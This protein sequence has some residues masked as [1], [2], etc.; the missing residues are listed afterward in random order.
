MFTFFS[1]AVNHIK[2]LYYSFIENFYMFL[3]RFGINITPTHY[4]MADRRNYQEW[5]ANNSDDILKVLGCSELPV[6]LDINRNNKYNTESSLLLEPF[7][8]KLLKIQSTIILSKINQFVY[9]QQMNRNIIEKKLGADHTKLDPEKMLLKLIQEY[10]KYKLIYFHS[11]EDNLENIN[12]LIKYIEKLIVLTSIKQKTLLHNLLITILDNLNTAKNI[13]YEQ[14]QLLKIKHEI[15]LTS[16]LL[17]STI[18]NIRVFFYNLFHFSS[19]RRNDLEQDINTAIKHRIGS[20][21]TSHKINHWLI[22]IQNI[23]DKPVNFHT[24]SLD[25]YLFLLQELNNYVFNQCDKNDKELSTASPVF[26]KVLLSTKPTAQKYISNRWNEIIQIQEQLVAVIMHYKLLDYLNK[27]L[28]NAY[29][30]TNLTHIEDIFIVLPAIK[31]EALRFVEQFRKLSVW[32]RFFKNY[33]CNNTTTKEQAEI[34][35]QLHAIRHSIIDALNEVVLKIDKIFEI[36]KTK[37]YQMHETSQQPGIKPSIEN[38]QTLSIFVDFVRQK[39]AQ[40]QETIGID[41]DKKLELR[42]N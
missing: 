37:S 5:I 24:V 34:T 17:N 4:T 30:G 10:V 28:E 20:D 16:N 12:V 14:V 6:Y 29:F 11:T 40:E 35:E 23:L 18:A 1:K 19:L 38:V 2:N 39:P 8:T 26:T 33:Q 27:D 31:Q 25:G 3:R 21:L 7:N 36:Y 15:S 32:D 41:S 9:Q 13:I 42:A 22:A